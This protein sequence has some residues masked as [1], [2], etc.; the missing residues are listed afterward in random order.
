MK[1]ADEKIGR[2]AT[3]CCLDVEIKRELPGNCP[4]VRGRGCPL[5][6]RSD[7]RSK[8][9]QEALELANSRFERLLAAS[10][11]ALYALRIE[12]E[13]I[14]PAWVSSNVAQMTGFTPQETQTYEWWASNL[15]PDDRNRAIEDAWQAFRNAS[16]YEMEYRFQHRAGNWIWL[17]DQARIQ[18]NE[19]GTL[20]V[21]GS[22]TDITDRKELELQ[23]HQSQ[24]MEAIGRFAGG[25]AHDFNNML[26]V[27]V[28][29]S[30]MLM[31]SA[32][33]GE[34]AEELDQVFK[35]GKRASELTKQLLAFSRRQ[36]HRPQVVNLNEVIVGAHK[37]LRHV[38]GEDV[39]IVTIP[40]PEIWMVRADVS[41]IEQVL[42]NLAVNARDAMEKGGKLALRTTNVSF[43]KPAICRTGIRQPGEYVLLEV[44]DNGCGMTADVL[45]HIFEPFFTTK[46]QGKGTGL[47]LAVSFGSIQQNGGHLE[48]SSTPGDGTTF[49]IY[50]PRA[51]A[52]KAE[53]AVSNK[54]K[55]LPL[56]SETILLVEDEM[57]VRNFTAKAL[58]R[59]GYR[60]VEAID[61]EEGLEAIKSDTDDEIK[62][63]L[64]DVVMP[65]LGGI[66]LSEEV[67]RI[68]PGMKMLFCS[69]YA[70]S[71]GLQNVLNSPLESFIPKPFTADELTFK[72]RAQLDAC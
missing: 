52:M 55:T 72:V 20:D 13:R 6:D 17:R 7:N 57:L 62:L 14:T 33:E 67:R 42:M 34:W 44:C 43:D 12:G 38:I 41:Q 63:V 23:L 60:V 64:T 53:R 24:K 30:Q 8:C 26:T 36:I 19:D 25:I 70:E 22:W 65:R 71:A 49:K 54:Q 9:A 37:M 15:H 29:Y 56:G 35:A 2:E 61:G 47:G 21:V 45:D 51:K 69:G 11:V 18:R 31:E 50:L 3:G 46:I 39:E 68:R 66:K 28:G 16:S 10:P 32:K 48:V 59:M 1:R 58:R 5:V 4:V 27:V 40:L